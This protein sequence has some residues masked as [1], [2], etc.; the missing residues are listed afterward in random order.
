[1]KKTV[2]IVALIIVFALAGYFL[3]DFY[4]N[5]NRDN[6]SDSSQDADPKIRIGRMELVLAHTPSRVLSEKNFLEK[7]GIKNYEFKE[8]T[9]GSK[10]ALALGAN[11]IDVAFF[12]AAIPAIANG[13]PAEIIG[14]NGKGGVQLVCQTP[15]IDSLPDLKNKKIGTIGPSSSPTTIFNLA[16]EENNNISSEDM[17][18]MHID[19]TNIVMALTEKKE[20][21]C[22]V[23]VYPLSSE[24]KKRGAYIAL[25]QKEIY[26]NGNYPLTFLAARK[27]FMEK[28]PELTQKLVEAH[29]DTLNWITENE[30]E[31]VEIMKNYFTENGVEASKKDLTFGMS[32][33]IF[34]PTIN[35]QTMQ[36]LINSMHKSGVLDKQA[37]VDDITNCSFGLCQN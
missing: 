8:F 28:N 22:A 35:K 37:P 24:A 17:S 16:L 30:E 14:L 21:D 9:Q 18:F 3:N 12:G 33:N 34:T 25:D 11:E 23:L 31:S 36:N 1:M 5:K 15:E 13:L 26:N 6:N 4:Q 27:D 2:T 7:N 32:T 19:R 20:I 10:A 29:K